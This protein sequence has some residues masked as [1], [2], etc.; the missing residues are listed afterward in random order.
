MGPAASLEGMVR[1]A[2]LPVRQMLPDTPSS[3]HALCFAQDSSIS[4]LLYLQ[5]NNYDLLRT[6][7]IH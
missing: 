2:L 4:C 7:F 5:Y 6:P 3:S 1:H